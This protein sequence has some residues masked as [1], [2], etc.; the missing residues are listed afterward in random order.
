MGAGLGLSTAGLIPGVGTASGVGKVV[1]KLTKVGNR[2]LMP[3]FTT[4]GL[5][6]A[7][8]GLTDIIANGNFTLENARQVM[9][10][11]MAI[12]SIRKNIAGHKAVKKYGES[13]E[14]KVKTDAPEEDMLKGL[15]KEKQLEIK[16]KAVDAAVKNNA[17]LKTVNGN[18]V[19]WVDDSGNITDY[20]KA[21]EGLRNNGHITDKMLKENRHW[22]DGVKNAA[23]KTKVEVEDKAKSA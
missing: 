3:L 1:K 13:V 2:L 8:D 16:K 10:G 6:S 17:D 21:W 15:S 18:K 11:L 23:G 19:E 12:K 14:G 7:A 5:V 9:N 20:N 22:F 4:Y